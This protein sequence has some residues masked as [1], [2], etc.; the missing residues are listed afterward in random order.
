MLMSMHNFTTKILILSLAFFMPLFLFTKEIKAVEDNIV[1]S[2]NFTQG[3]DKWQSVRKNNF[4]QII[5]SEAHAL[6][7]HM[8]T[9][10]ELVPKDEYWNQD[11]KNISY[12]M[13]YK[14]TSGADK[15]VSFH[16]KDLSN[17]Y[18]IHFVNGIYELVHLKKDDVVWS[19]RGDLVMKLNQSYHLKFELRGGHIILFVDDQKIIDVIDPTFDD[20][21]GKIGIKAGTGA[22]FPTHIIYDNILVKDLDKENT[23]LKVESLKQTDPAWASE[24]YDSAITWSKEGSG[25]DRWGCLI[26]SISMIMNF[27]NI[28]QM[29]DGLAVTPKTLNDWLKTQPDGYISTGLVNW[30]AVTRLTK[31]IA[32]L[33]DTVKL[34]YL[35]L[36]NTFTEANDITNSIKPTIEK[37][38]ENQPTIIEIDGHFLVADGFN[39]A[40]TDLYIKD[41]SY[42]YTKFSEHQKTL[43]STRF[44]TPSHTDLSYIQIYSE[45]ILDLK[46]TDENNKEIILEQYTEQITANDQ[47]EKTNKM[48]FY[49]FAKPTSH[50]YFINLIA[51]DTNQKIDFNINLYDKN[52]DVF[53]KKITT[54]LYKENQRI[55]INFDKENISNSQIIL[56]T[57]YD[58]LEKTLHHLYIAGEIKNTYAYLSIKNLINFYQQNNYVSEKR[59][60]YLLKKIDWYQK[61]MSD[62]AHQ[63]LIDL[64]KNR[65]VV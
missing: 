15:N 39:K 26:S 30:Q 59:K 65:L 45:N 12:E 61:N 10:T 62:D 51:K 32:D 24:E 14:Y 58:E 2:D 48:Y 53:S 1:F 28:K 38:I 63:I 52:A 60:A 11:W 20:D 4:W 21:Y 3:F 19:Q 35:R 36:E 41:P 5:D 33:N 44:L 9:L 31:K 56:T 34:E 16:F 23:I 27:H 50:K 40:E 49:N 42:E 17:W 13:D 18:E 37:I 54:N 6:I 29:P 43:I 8:M 7:P 55:E 57:N 22:S 64:I 47:K 46:L 25:I